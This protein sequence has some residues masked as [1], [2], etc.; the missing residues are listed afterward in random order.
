VA[1]FKAVTLCPVIKVV[2]TSGQT[3]IGLLTVVTAPEKLSCNGVQ[4][5]SSIN[6]VLL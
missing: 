6:A 4:G 2:D 5:R 3:A 1:H